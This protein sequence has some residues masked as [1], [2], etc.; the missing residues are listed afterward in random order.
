MRT[1][2][3]TMP[4]AVD[5]S[6]LDTFRAFRNSLYNCF[7]RR[8]DALFELTDAQLTAEAVPSPV[9]LRACSVLIAV[10]GQPLR[11]AQPG[12]NRRPSPTKAARRPSACWKPNARLRRGRERLGSLRR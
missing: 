10:V 12:T 9:H 5:S 11:R 8:A 6:V 7:Y 1:L 3:G 2:Q 4:R